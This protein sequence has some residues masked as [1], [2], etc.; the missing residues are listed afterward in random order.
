MPGPRRLAALYRWPGGVLPERL[1]AMAGPVVAVRVMVDDGEP[2]SA[3]GHAVLPAP[4]DLAALAQRWQGRGL[5]ATCASS[6]CFA[7]TGWKSS[8]CRS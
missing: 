3:V 5:L 2:G 4:D 7:D 1:Q 8:G 6:S